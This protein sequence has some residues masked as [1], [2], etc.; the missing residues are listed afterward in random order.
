MSPGFSS[1]EK[2][3]SK[4]SLSKDGKIQFGHREN[5][6]IFKK[7]YSELATD[8]LEKLTIAPNKFCGSNTE[9]NY[10]DTFRNNKIVVPVT[11]RIR[12][13]C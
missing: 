9:D 1:E 5:A 11:R 6:N 8:L 10:A 7:F 13:C 4:V 2:N 12:R 3:Y